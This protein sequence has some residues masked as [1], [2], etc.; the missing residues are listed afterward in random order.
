MHIVL[1]K[2]SGFVPKLSTQIQYCKLN[3]SFFVILKTGVKYDPIKM[4]NG[5]KRPAL[6]KAA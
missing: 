4:M 6:Q 5:I 1:K 3:K 2:V